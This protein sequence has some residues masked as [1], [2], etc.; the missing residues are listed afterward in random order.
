MTAVSPYRQ[1]AE[2][3]LHKNSKYIPQIVEHMIN[4]EQATLLVSLPGTADQMAERLNRSIIDIDADFKDMFRKGLVF[5]KEKEGIITWRPPAHIAQF[6]DATLVWPEATEEFY[7]LWHDYMENEWPNL[8]PIL[9]SFL[10]KPVTRVIP[11][12]K[13]IE[14]G[15]VQVLAPENVKEIINTATRVAVTKCT[16]RITMRKCESPIEICLQVNRGADYTIER[17]SGREL[18][19]NEAIEMIDRAQEAGLIHVTMNKSNV[20]TFI[21]NCCGCCCQSFTLL[22]S[23]G[24]PL[25]DPSRYCPEI[26]ESLCTGCGECEERCWF[27]AINIAN[28]ISELNSEKCLGCGQCAF[29][30][31]EKAISMI[32][33]RDSSFIPE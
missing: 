32:E 1:F 22:I 26:D 11:V 13:S 14:T 19:K 20:G 8:A 2:N 21:C 25:C 15:N 18:S 6:H 17:G 27:N 3:M 33:K 12:G 30:C 7:T 23:D 28:D 4:L 29:V 16:C 5:K 24:I 9:A 10:P 31:P